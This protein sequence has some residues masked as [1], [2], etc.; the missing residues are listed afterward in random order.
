MSG[1]LYFV[2]SGEYVK[3]GTCRSGRLSKRLS[4]L[5]TGN[6]Q[7]LEFLGAVPCGPRD[8][9][10]IHRE[11][12]YLRTSGEWFHFTPLLGLFI[13]DALAEGALPEL[14]DGGTAADN[15]LTQCLSRR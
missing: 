1:Q 8:E 9:W 10:R 14:P 2:R 12:Q 5:Q 3:I 13:R 7:P 11:W 6:P 4:E 15:D